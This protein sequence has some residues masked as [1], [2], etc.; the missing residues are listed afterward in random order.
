MTP[1]RSCQRPALRAWEPFLI[2][3]VLTALAIFCYAASL[4][5]AF[6]AE[7]LY[8]SQTLD[9]AAWL[10]IAFFPGGGL[11]RPTTY[12]FW[13]VN[14]FLW[15]DLSFPYRVLF[16]GLHLVNACLVYALTRRATRSRLASLTAGLLFISFLTGAQSVNWLSTASNVV[17]SLFGYVLA[18][19]AYL[20]LLDQPSQPA[21]QRTLR[22]L[23]A[24][25]ALITALGATEL[26][27]TWPGAA[28]LMALWVR[29]QRTG[30]LPFSLR[31]L[32]VDRP[33]LRAM[34]GSLWPIL[35]AW[36]GFLLLRT[37]MVRGVGGYGEALHLRVGWFL[38]L[39]LVTYVSYFLAPL[40]DV[41]RLVDPSDS[42]YA[43]LAA[44]RAVAV[45]LL[46]G[47]VWLAR[48]SLWAVGLFV[49]VLVPVLNIP[50]LHRAY[51]AAIAAALMAATAVAHWQRRPW[52]A[53]VRRPMLALIL[54]VLVIA[55]V[56]QVNAARVLTARYVAASRWSQQVVT[57]THALV[58]VPADGTTF[59]FI[60]LPVTHAGV[61]VYTWGLPEALQKT[62]RNLTLD[63]YLVYARP[64]LR[65]VA[66]GTQLALAD[67]AQPAPFEQVYL[68]YSTSGAGGPTLTQLSPAELAALV[69]AGH[70]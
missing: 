29:H 52:P 2:P 66:D 33:W 32:A 57:T 17:L 36:A 27:F 9:N 42:L 8:L 68:L 61:Y 35:A 23:I 67:A 69:A 64:E 56:L 59:Y 60:D 44:H 19:Y 39:D 7:D 43:W 54:S 10:K 26:A 14:D 62:Y 38:I 49:I 40:R 5:N 30:R 34:L 65:R 21:W 53:P 58:P 24:I 20:A 18:L 15:G 41:W 37:L 13:A 55:L 4:H 1:P 12:A 45:L 3:A 70:P 48:P 46:V 50:E 47:G 28:I 63:A 25:V 6:M 16:I 11:Y 31:P 22:A 51:F